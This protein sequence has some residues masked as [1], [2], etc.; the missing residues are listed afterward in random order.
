ME[1][2]WRVKD[3]NANVGES[4]AMILASWTVAS[5]CRTLLYPN[6]LLRMVA[7]IGGRPLESSDSDIASGVVL[8]N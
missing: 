1:G 3:L 8:P 4:I 2:C 5:D 7:Q 6:S